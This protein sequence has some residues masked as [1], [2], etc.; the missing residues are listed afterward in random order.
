MSNQGHSPWMCPVWPV[1]PVTQT[2]DPPPVGE[3]MP[4]SEPVAEGHD[5]A[6]SGSG[7]GPVPPPPT[8]PPEHRRERQPRPLPEVK[9]PSAAE[10]ARHRLTHIPYRRWCRW[11][12]QARMRNISHF[13]LPPFSREVPL[14]VMDYA[15]V[16][17][18]AGP[19]FLTILVARLYPSRTVFA[20]PCP[21]KGGRP[22]CG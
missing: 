15:C 7:D 4:A 18:G 3:G 22:V 14:L 16:K 19:K 13:R 2:S 20:V 9:P 5:V 8:A 21:A 17:R 12:V 1:S 11:C 10:E 6:S